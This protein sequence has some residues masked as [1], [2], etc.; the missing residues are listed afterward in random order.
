VLVHNYYE[1]NLTAPNPYCYLFGLEIL[2]V[3]HM[4]IRE[5]TRDDCEWILHHR[6]GMFTDMGE[7][8][9]FIQKTARLT[10]QFLEDDWTKVYRYFLVEENNEVISGCGISVF[11]VPPQ[12]IQ[13]MGTFAYLSNMFVEPDRRR[14]GIGRELL[15]HVIKVCREEGVGLLILHASD[16]GLPF[17]ESEGFQSLKRLMQLSTIQKPT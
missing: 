5:A 11:R 10:E 17:Y 14:M 16:D 4:R 9:D 7:S 13:N 6:I 3:E 15:N 2:S 8:H 1:K 12:A